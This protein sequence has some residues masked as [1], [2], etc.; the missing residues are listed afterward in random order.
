MIIKVEPFWMLTIIWTGKT[1]GPKLKGL[2]VGEV[3]KANLF[4]LSLNS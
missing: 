2:F 4:N 3:I 1:F